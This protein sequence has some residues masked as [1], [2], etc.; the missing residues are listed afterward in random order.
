MLKAFQEHINTHFPYLKEHKVIVACSGGVDSILLAHLC[1]QSGIDLALAHCNFKLRGSESDE[2][3]SFV[4]DLATALSIPV[5]VK[6]LEA[7]TY[8]NVKQLSIQ[9]AARELRYNWFHSLIEAHPYDYVL[10]AHHADDNLETF[11]INLSRGTGIEGLTGIPP[12]N[13]HY[14]RPLL[15]FSRNEL[16]TYAKANQ[17]DWR[18]D[19]SNRQTKYLRNKLR[20]DVIPILKEI[21]PAILANFK[22]TV[23][24]LHD[25][26]TMINDTVKKI[27]KELFEYSSEDQSVI[28]ISIAK[29]QALGDTQVYLHA[30]FKEFGFT[31]WKDVLRLL[32]SQSGK[33]VSSA[34]H[35]LVKDR[36]N[37]LLGPVTDIA[38][39]QSYQIF[40]GESAVIL[41]EQILKL[42]KVSTIEEVGANTIYVPADSLH[43]PLE[44]RRWEQG[45]VFY[46]LGMKGKKKLSK[47]FKDQ[48]LSLL[49]KEKVWVLCSND[50]IVWVLGYRADERFRVVPDNKKILKI[51]ITT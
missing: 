49:D 2:D 12:V 38:Q 30:L 16:V 17:I 6:H 11:L 3:E 40:E 32:D 27:Q 1:Y 18:E 48:K 19:S 24:Y 28:K 51:T 35:R 20:H 10:T 34:T 23:R 21:N 31:A 13:G 41:P 46:P 37:L 50:Q 33:Y 5:F 39:K 45:D 8:G 42:K 44:I 22:K 26:A 43:Y 25:S 29:L 47:Y 15:P 9:M 4:R 7:E 36:E 14:L